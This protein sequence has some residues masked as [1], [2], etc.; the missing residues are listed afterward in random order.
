MPKRRTRLVDRL[1]IDQWCATY[2]LLLVVI[3]GERSRGVVNSKHLIKDALAKGARYARV[4]TRFVVPVIL[5]RGK[6]ICRS[7][8]LSHKLET[9][10]QTTAN[11]IKDSIF[12]DDEDDQ[13]DPRSTPPSQAA[14]PGVPAPK[15]FMHGPQDVSMSFGHA[16]S[17]SRRDATQNYGLFNMVSASSTFINGT[18][19]AAQASSSVLS[20]S[21][22]DPPLASST[23]SAGAELKEPSLMDKYRNC[24]IALLTIL[25]ITHV[26]APQTRHPVFVALVSCAPRFAT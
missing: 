2:P 26:R 9:V 21:P 13:I 8:T 16:D 4:R 20:T 22:S 14:Q 19:A 12:V 5:F 1:F 3:T 25:R 23:A 7:S 18:F 6:N 17:G 10:F 15:G 11:S 24:D